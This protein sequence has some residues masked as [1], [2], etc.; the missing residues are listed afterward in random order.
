VEAS[1]VGIPIWGEVELAWRLR[2]EPAAP[3]LAITGTNGK[4]TTVRM[5]ESM[6]QGRGLRAVAVGNVGVSLIDAVTADEPYD[7]LAVELSSQQLHFAPSMR[8]EAGVLLTSPQTPRLA[9]RLR[10]LRQGEGSGLD[11]GDCDRQC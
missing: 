2:A 8:A 1:A 5:L 11:G 3:W 7:V 10:C 4:T 9:R 6:L